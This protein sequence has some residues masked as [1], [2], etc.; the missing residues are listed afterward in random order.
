MI[1]L[2]I[3]SIST[4]WDK[5]CMI[6]N[7]KT[8]HNNVI[9]LQDNSGRR[10]SLIKHENDFQP[11]SAIIDGFTH[12]NVEQEKVMVDTFSA[13][14]GYSP[15]VEFTCLNPRWENVWREWLGFLNN[16]PLCV[17]IEYLDNLISLIGLG[18]GTTPSGDDFLTGYITASL[19][20]NRTL[21]KDFVEK[22]TKNLYRTTWFS[23][24]MI[25]D[26]LNGCIW[27]RGKD[28]C[29]ALSGN[30][31]RKFIESV[32]SIYSWGHL[33]GKAWLAGFAYALEIKNI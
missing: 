22:I 12:P 11:R 2:Q 14:E 29:L 18:L 1:C 23:G 8:V 19:F 9:N 15:E 33:S 5:N 7:I 10:Y 25:E 32:S 27:K 30:S 6:F 31:E 4:D 21:K 28:L 16:E 20:T 26:A 17:L 3:K 13:E 24:Q